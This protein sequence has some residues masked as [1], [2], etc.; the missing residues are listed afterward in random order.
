MRVLLYLTDI[1]LLIADF[2]AARCLSLTVIRQVAA[3]GGHYSYF[4]IYVFNVYCRCMD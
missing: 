1:T 3:M 4:S 2:V